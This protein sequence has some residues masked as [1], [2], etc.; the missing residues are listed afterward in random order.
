VRRDHLGDL[1]PHGAHGIQRQRRVLENDGH[2]GAAH[3]LHLPFAEAQE[4]APAEAYRSPDHARGSRQ[5]AQD[6]QEQGRLAA[7][8]LAQ[9]ADGLAIRHVQADFVERV[10]WRVTR[11]PVSDGQVPDLEERRHAR[12]ISSPSHVAARGACRRRTREASPHR[13][14]AD[15]TLR[16]AHG[17]LS[18]RREPRPAAPDAPPKPDGLSRPDVRLVHECL[19][20]NEDAW[21]ALLAKYKNLIFSIPMRRGIPRDDAADIFQRVCVL[22]LADLPNLR[23][24]EAL[25]MWL[26]RVTSRECVRWRR[27][28]QPPVARE[29]AEAALAVLPDEGPAPEEL[30]AQVQDEQMLREAVLALPPRCRQLVQMLFFETPARPYQQVASALGLAAG[31]IGFIRGRCLTRLR[32]ELERLGYR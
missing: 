5:E 20:G 18:S 1:R 27:Q 30:I 3:R 24:A 26:I 14:A 29:W 23:H 25:P 13:G 2:L 31:S 9:E 4:L 21:C 11:G 16:A 17:R 10:E 19:R 6:G 15:T 8:G 28:E 12:M 32:R 7:P 22:L